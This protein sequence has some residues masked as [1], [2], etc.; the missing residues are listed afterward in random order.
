VSRSRLIVALDVP[1]REKALRLAR[2]LAGKVAMVK[3]GLELFVT[4]G[5]ALVSEVRGLGLDVFLDLKLHDIPRT[6]EAAARG[7]A[8]L[9]ARLLTVHAQG[10]REMV[11]AARGVLPKST[12]LLAVTVL[13]SLDAQALRELGSEP[14]PSG[15][16]QRL[17]QLAL[18][19]GADGLVCSAHE[20]VR[21][22]PL[23]G[24][25]VVPGI[26]PSG[27]DSGDQKRVATPAEAV[28]AGASYIVVGRPVVAAVDPLAVVEQINAD[29]GA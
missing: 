14:D 11:E 10:G 21:L 29:L 2:A 23:G 8:D 4:H 19:A 5:A 28:R 6:V 27:S 25:R 22:A 9:G 20:L 24:L 17:G 16:A 15:L 12:E 13:T 3:I 18:A 1:E 7:V 26:R